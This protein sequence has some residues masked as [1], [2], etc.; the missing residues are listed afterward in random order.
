M[1][2]DVDDISGRVAEVAA[3]H[4]ITADIGPSF[5]IAVVHPGSRRRLVS[6]VCTLLRFCR[7][8]VLLREPPRMVIRVGR[9]RSCWISYREQNH[10]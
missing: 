6:S 10:I 4:L 7:V 5:S 8:G 1:I 2:G 9:R 3:G